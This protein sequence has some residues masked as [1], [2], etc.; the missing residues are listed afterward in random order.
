[1]VHCCESLSRVC[2]ACCGVMIANH[3]PTTMW[4]QSLAERV[5]G[6]AICVYYR[7]DNAV[8][9]RND[10]RERTLGLENELKRQEEEIAAFKLEAKAGHE[11]AAA[12]AAEAAARPTLRKHRC[13]LQC[14]ARHLCC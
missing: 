1:M 7:L 12:A 4:P 3:S 8:K 14:S 10:A 13:R 11:A 9:Q 6:N 2:L 5:Y